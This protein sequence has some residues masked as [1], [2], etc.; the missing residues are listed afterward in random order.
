MKSE[1]SARRFNGDGFDKL[2]S[3][4]ALNES[5]DAVNV[6]PS[7]PMTA[8]ATLFPGLPNELRQRQRHGAMDA[9]G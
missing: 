5:T 3:I 7:T 8:M 9:N 1:S 6:N 2:V 4:G